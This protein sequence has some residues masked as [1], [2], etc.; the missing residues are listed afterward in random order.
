MTQKDTKKVTKLTANELVKQG[1]KLDVQEEFVVKIGDA[2]YTL[3]HDTYFRITKQHKV[4]DDLMAFFN[5][6]N[7]RNELFD[8]ATPYTALLVLKHFTTLEVS[9]DIDE[10][11][12]LMEVLVD[13]QVLDV[14]LNELPEE[15]L[16]KVFELLTQTVDNVRTNLEEAEAEADRI[17]E[18]VQND[19]VKEMI[20]DNGEEAEASTDSE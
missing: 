8:L 4:I 5:E 3:S 18:M 2:D 14:L 13:L 10:A 7:N 16:T 20:E 11:L 6:G 17:L 12:A 19:E 9:D 1:K 15:E